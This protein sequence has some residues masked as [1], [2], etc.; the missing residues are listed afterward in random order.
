MT[1]TKSYH[2]RWCDKE[3][4][5]YKPCHD[6]EYNCALNPRKMKG[7]EAFEPVNVAEIAEEVTTGFAPI[8]DDP[9]TG[10]MPAEETAETPSPGEDPQL[11][12]VDGLANLIDARIGF[13]W[14]QMESRLNEQFAKRDQ[15]Y[16]Q[17]FKD[18]IASLPGI[19]QQSVVSY[20]SGQA[21]GGNG[22]GELS[23]VPPATPPLEN[24][25]HPV[26][27]NPPNSG[28]NVLGMNF[29][30]R[31]LALEYLKAKGKGNP[32]TGLINIFMGQN[33][34]KARP[35]DSKYFTR[36]MGLA[37]GV[38]RMK[39]IDSTAMALALKSQAEQML[40]EGISP[41]QRDLYIGQKSLC[42]AFLDGLNLQKA[43]DQTQGG[44]GA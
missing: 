17:Q 26:A 37:Q 19:I 14:S 28:I 42:D 5:G 43:V 40:K 27:T 32:A 7:G 20:L 9:G 4:Y 2:C 31:E 1:K 3:L 33:K 8:P 13:R 41:Q 10:D 15:E 23:D 25:T 16:G 22:S 24:V 30:W 18:A 34:Q 12:A 6:H 21:G 29:D 11:D 36:G 44:E 39:N 38:L 35:T